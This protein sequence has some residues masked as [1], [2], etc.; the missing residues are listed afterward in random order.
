MAS[1][2]NFN[3]PLTFEQVAQIAR[4]LPKP[5]REKL[6]EMLQ[7]EK[8]AVQTHLASQATLGQDWLT[9]EEDSA[10]QHL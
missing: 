8:D 1:T 9:L 3:L 2:M 7:Q 4:Q 5:E 10:W 6:A